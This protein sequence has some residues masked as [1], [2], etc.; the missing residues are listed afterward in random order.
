VPAK[1]VSRLSG[2]SHGYL[3]SVRRGR[4]NPSLAAFVDIANVLGYDVRLVK[5]LP[6]GD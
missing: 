2:Y 1:T 6:K 5:R 4:I 3:S